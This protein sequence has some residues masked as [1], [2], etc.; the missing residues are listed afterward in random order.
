MVCILYYDVILSYT[1]C[2]LC[3]CVNCAELFRVCIIIFVLKHACCL[4][5]CTRVIVFF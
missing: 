3:V 2:V 4:R 1:E 5:A